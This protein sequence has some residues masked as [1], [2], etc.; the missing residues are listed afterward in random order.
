MAEVY[1][2]DQCGACCSGKLVDLYEVDLLREP[3]LKEYCHPV[4]EADEVGFLNACPHCPFLADKQCSIYPTRPVICVVFKA[5]NEQCQE[6]RAL[7]G[8][9]PLEPAP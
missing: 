2:C 9:L 4:R 8:L 3:K 5:G 7:H 6:A 1:V